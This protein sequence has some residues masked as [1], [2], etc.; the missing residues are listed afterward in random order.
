MSIHDDLAAKRVLFER[1]LQVN[2][3]GWKVTLAYIA[4]QSPYRFAVWVNELKPVHVWFEANEIVALG[5]SGDEVWLAAFF[6]KLDGALAEEH[7]SSK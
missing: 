1:K 5:N 4:N 6:R 7:I 3:P 2:H